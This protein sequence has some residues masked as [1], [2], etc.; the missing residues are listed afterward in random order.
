MKISIEDNGMGMT[1]KELEKVTNDKINNN[2]LSFGL[3]GTVER[4]KIFY[5]ISNVYKIE[6]RKR[7][8]TKVTITIPIEMRG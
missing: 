6:S 2:N 3:R 8:G 7:Y 4:L 1:E 5:G